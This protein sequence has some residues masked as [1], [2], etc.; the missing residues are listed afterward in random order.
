MKKL[1]LCGLAILFVLVG[2][3][4]VGPPLSLLYRQGE[5]EI[6]LLN[7]LSD[8]D[9]EVFAELRADWKSRIVITDYAGLNADQK[10]SLTKKTKEQDQKVK[11]ILQKEININAQNVFIGLAPAKKSIDIRLAFYKL[12]VLTIAYA[13]EGSEFYKSSGLLSTIKSSLDWLY[14]NY[15]NENIYYIYDNWWDFNIQIPQNICD[16][17]ILL[18][19]DLE[20]DFLNKFL[21]AVDHFNADPFNSVT[22]FNQHY[23]MQVANLLDRLIVKA[24]TGIIANSS[25]HMEIARDGLSDVLPYVKKGNGFYIDGSYIDH[26]AVP[27]T[28]NYGLVVLQKTAGLL[29]LLQNSNWPVTDVNLANVFSWIT[30][31]YMPFYYSGGIMDA[32]AGR[33]LWAKGTGMFA[34]GAGGLFGIME[35][36]MLAP[37]NLR[38]EILAFTKYQFLQHPY[39]EQFINNLDFGKK[40]MLENFLLDSSVA[41]YKVKPL[42]KTYNS[43]DRVV[44]HRSNWSASLAMFSSRI[45]AFS[46]GNDENLTGWNTGSGALYLYNKDRTHYAEQYWL[47]VDPHRLAGITSDFTRREIVQWKSYLSEKDWAGGVSLKNAYGSAGMDFSNKGATNSNLRAKKSWFFFDNEIVCLGSNI[48]KTQNKNKVVTIAENRK[49]NNLEK[50]EIYIDG[51]KQENKFFKKSSHANSVFLETQEDSIAYFFPKKAN[52]TISLSSRKNDIRLLSPKNPKEYSVRN[53]FG[54]DIEHGVYPQEE[55]YSYIMAPGMRQENV[56]T[57]SNNLPIEI[58]QKDNIAHAIKHKE[59]GITAISFW[60]A[61]KAGDITSSNSAA[62]IMQETKNEV[63]IAISDSTQKLKSMKFEIEMKKIQKIKDKSSSLEAYYSGNKLY[64]EID[65]KDSNGKIFYL[66]L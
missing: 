21:R 34:R 23:R 61:G 17:L 15:Y 8:A 49:V 26:G 66:N 55:S 31:S 14:S 63:Q 38:S 11:E 44:H 58:L 28:G 62:F 52:L 29:F 64:I 47:S 7:S 46:T 51:Q 24:L 54:I 60:K 53:Y 57:Y 6:K 37:E 36:G 10:I 18:Y 4:S 20:E 27:Y 32:V 41:N 45:S 5:P 25:E 42:H 65:C 39:L 30:D 9:A 22:I 43:M 48:S 59:L 33:M 12:R 19:S 35:L 40:L 13:T 1:I 50:T 16:M 3:T 2:C 56:A